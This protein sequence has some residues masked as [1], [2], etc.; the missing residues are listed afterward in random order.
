E[1][2]DGVAE[3]LFVGVN[4]LVESCAQSCVNLFSGRVRVKPSQGLANA[5]RETGGCAIAG[6][7]ALE[8]GVVEYDA[9]RLVPD[10]GAL[11]F[12]HASDEEIR[13]NV[14]DPRFDADGSAHN[15]VPLV[16]GHHFIGSD[17]KRVANR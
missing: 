5:L 15:P 2:S 7:E 13:R 8:L 16:P 12:R 6:D 9:H 4:H 1:T 10:Q 3:S 11:E 14:N 17:V